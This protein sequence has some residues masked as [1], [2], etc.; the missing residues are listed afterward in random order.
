MFLVLGTA[1]DC[2]VTTVHEGNDVMAANEIR[3]FTV[4]VNGG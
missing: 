4:G 1:I 3:V 2:V